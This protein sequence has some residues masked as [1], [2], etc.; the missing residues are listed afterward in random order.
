M[1]RG[2]KRHG[3]GRKP[4]PVEQRKLE[5]NPGHR[6]LPEPLLIAGRP[7]L[8]ELMEPPP[9]LPVEAHA[10]WTETVAHLVDCGLVDRVDAAA[11]DQL[12]TAYARWRQAGQVI[13]DLAEVMGEGRA[14]WA[15][16]SK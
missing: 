2:G 5:G 15:L 7:H 16:M 14:G 3:S 12:A 11:L 9:H 4:T 10:F 8:H 1:P 13:A 6:P